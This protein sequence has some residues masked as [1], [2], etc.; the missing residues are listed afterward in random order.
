MYSIIICTDNLRSTVL[1]IFLTKI[2]NCIITIDY[3]L[4]CLF[5]LLL[6]QSAMKT[7]SFS[8]V[9]SRMQLNFKIGN[10]TSQATV[11]PRRLYCEIPASISSVG[12]SLQ[13]TLYQYAACSRQLGSRKRLVPVYLYHTES[14]G[15]NS[16]LLWWRCLSI[17]P[18]RDEPV[19]C[20]SSAEYRE[21]RD[22]ELIAITTQMCGTDVDGPIICALVSVQVLECARRE[23]SRLIY[24]T[25]W[26]IA[27]YTTN[28]YTQIHVHTARGWPFQHVTCPRACLHAWRHGLL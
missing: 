7:L 3:V 2:Y 10:K 14:F 27:Q 23:W 6:M 18:E 5:R 24:T 15:F 22:C 4:T 28:G 25:Q 19:C 11:Q 12:I 1:I 17:M 26:D 16:G 9:H 8:I 21:S 13:H 20:T